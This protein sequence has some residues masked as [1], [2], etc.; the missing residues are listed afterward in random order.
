MFFPRHNAFADAVGVGTLTVGGAAKGLLHPPG[1]ILRPTEP[2][3]QSLVFGSMAGY[4]M[5]M[6]T[7][8]AADASRAITPT[9][10]GRLGEA[11][12]T[13]HWDQV[14]KA[15]TDQAGA[16]MAQAQASH[17]GL[18]GRADAM[19]AGRDDES[20]R[21]YMTTGGLNP[22]YK[23]GAPLGQSERD[24]AAAATRLKA[25]TVITDAQLATDTQR[26]QAKAEFEGMRQ[27]AVATGAFNVQSRS[28]PARVGAAAKFTQTQS[29]HL[30]AQLRAHA[31]KF[32]VPQKPPSEPKKTEGQ[33]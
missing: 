33:P 15:L 7:A 27:Q 19:A 6:G 4:R 31:Q 14:D 16:R 24:E 32:G 1:G 12:L 26:A 20:V 25:Q 23:A 21:E 5:A 3:G 10:A 13:A 18:M 9:K 17:D 22:Q 30:E 8:T 2:R 28:H 29:A 11:K